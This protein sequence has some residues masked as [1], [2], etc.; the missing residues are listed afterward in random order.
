MS[1]RP[2]SVVH[3]SIYRLRLALDDLERAA[4]ERNLPVAR[5]IL[6]TEIMEAMNAIQR[7]RLIDTDILDCLI[8]TI[9]GV[10]DELWR[11]PR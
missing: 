8:D 4:G 5:Y 7:A 10:Q 6:D 2:I 1:R 11:K 3:D 9:E